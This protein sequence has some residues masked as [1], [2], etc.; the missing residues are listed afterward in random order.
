M[1]TE[2]DAGIFVFGGA[3]SGSPLS[4][5][6]AVCGALDSNKNSN[7]F[8]KGLAFFFFGSLSYTHSGV[9]YQHMNLSSA[10]RSRQ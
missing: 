1:K 5:A 4:S 8:I 6:I 10:R 9:Y 3:L 7:S 2:P